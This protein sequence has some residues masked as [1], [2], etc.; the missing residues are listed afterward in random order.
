M[1]ILFRQG[2]VPIE[3]H[4]RGESKIRTELKF[5]LDVFTRLL[6]APITIG[7]AHEKQRTTVQV[8][9]VKH[10]LD[11][12]VDGLRRNHSQFV[13][14]V[15]CVELRVS[16]VAAERHGVLAQCPDGAG[17]WI[18]SVLKSARKGALR[19][20]SG[21]EIHGVGIRGKDR[22]GPHDAKSRKDGRTKCVDRAIGSRCSG[23]S[24]T[25]RRELRHAK[26][27]VDRGVGL[28]ADEAKDFRNAQI[29]LCELRMA[30]R[31]HLAAGIQVL[32]ETLD[33][34]IRIRGDGRVVLVV[35]L[36]KQGMLRIR[37][38]VQISDRL[39]GKEIR[40][41]RHFGVLRERLHHSAGGGRI[42][43]H[44][45]RI[46][47]RNQ[48]VTIRQ[49]VREQRISDGVDIA[50]RGADSWVDHRIVKLQGARQV[51]VVRDGREA[52]G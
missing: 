28:F 18:E 15:S 17:R 20:C 34:R 9:V 52:C 42:V 25:C 14:P 12:L 49:L 19:S 24:H 48:I 29:G 10:A 44:R 35:I 41:T 23:K 27:L 32:G 30:E 43:D 36:R 40:C 47:G 2:T 33:H 6:G 7:V 37:I 38:P 5:V 13:S 50:W 1:P 3:A 26:R 51:I 22:S 21:A 39:V 8:V 16:E 46:C 11:E 4:S 45:I 31:D